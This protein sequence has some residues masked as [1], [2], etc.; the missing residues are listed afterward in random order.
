MGILIEEFSRNRKPPL[1]R[2][3]ETL[4]NVFAVCTN[5]G[6]NYEHEKAEITYSVF[7]NA[8]AAATG[9]DALDVFK[10][11]LR[12]GGT[13]LDPNG[14]EVPR[15]LFAALVESMR[16][17]ADPRDLLDQIATSMRSD[18]FLLDKDTQAPRYKF[19][20]GHVFGDLSK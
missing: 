17:R 19:V 3:R 10:F 18:V 14:N 8:D 5:I 12:N 4:H 16:T 1:Q 11:E 6:V 9:G 2:S 7:D 15:R 20:S 13:M